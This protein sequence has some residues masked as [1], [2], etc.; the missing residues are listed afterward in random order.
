MLFR[1]L[2]ASVNT[3]AISG[4]TIGI[5]SSLRR[6]SLLPTTSFKLQESA[7]RQKQIKSSCFGIL[8]Q[9]KKQFKSENPE[10][11]GL[12]ILIK[13]TNL[14]LQ[15]NKIMGNVWIAEVQ[16]TVDKIS[17]ISGN[18][19]ILLCAQ[20]FYCMIIKLYISLFHLS[21]YESV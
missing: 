5:S 7:R 9:T 4:T 16:S 14:Y 11:T 3:H 15:N 13:E 1:E 19:T 17:N 10:N 21:L 2:Q 20:M 12:K 18:K 8:R 6:N